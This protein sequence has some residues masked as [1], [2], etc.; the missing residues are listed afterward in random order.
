MADARQLA[1]K[2]FY[3]NGKAWE[4]C[5]MNDAGQKKKTRGKHMRTR[6]EQND[7]TEPNME[8][9][10][11]GTEGRY[12]YALPSYER[13][14][15]THALNPCLWGFVGII[16]MF[17]VVVG[18]LTLLSLMLNS[19]FHVISSVTE[20]Y[21]LAVDLT[22]IFGFTAIYFVGFI[23]YGRRLSTVVCLDGRD[24]IVGTAD[25]KGFRKLSIHTKAET[26]VEGAA[27][28]GSIAAAAATHSTG[29]LKGAA[30]A[31]SGIVISRML[32]CSRDEGFV[33]EAFFT[34]AYKKKTYRNAEFVGETRYRYHFSSDDGDFFLLKMYDGLEDWFHIPEMGKTDGSKII[35]RVMKRSVIVFLIA[36]LAVF[37]DNGVGVAKNEGYRENI[38]QSLD[39]FTDGIEAYGYKERM[40][41]FDIS[42][43]TD[44]F[45][46]AKRPEELH[47]FEKETDGLTDYVEIRYDKNGDTAY[48]NFCIYLTEEESVD[49]VEYALEASGLFEETDIAYYTEHLEAAFTDG[50]STETYARIEGENKEDTFTVSIDIEDGIVK[51]YTL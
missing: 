44:I 33:R 27:I 15:E 11:H 26:A 12:R 35:L 24:I 39:V 34:D 47:R 30:L 14:R 4:K 37:I 38:T 8:N 10:E 48:L 43:S 32:R 29:A 25:G 36:C 3:R 42:Y 5:F 49:E 7:Q 41:Q 13:E 28:A 40:S 19:V 46:T 2:K 51:A 1:A 17:S 9:A 23:A 20:D 6:R 31:D 50:F 16:S 18:A 21:M 22:C 45:I